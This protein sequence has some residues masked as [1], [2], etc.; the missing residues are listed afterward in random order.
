MDKIE[1]YII[2]FSKCVLNERHGTYGGQAGLKD[3]VVY[4]KENWIIKY[5]K[6]TRGMSDVE[7]LSYTTA[8]LSEYIGS[9]IYQILGFDAH[10]TL[11]GIRNNKLVVGCKDFRDDDELLLE[12]RT[13]KNAA[14]AELAD[15]LDRDFSETGSQHTVNLEELMTHLKQ[16]DILKNI[17]GLEEYFWNCVVVDILINNNDRNNGNWGILRKKGCADRIAPIFDNGGCLSNKLPEERILKMLSNGDAVSSSALNTVTVFRLNDKQLTARQML[18]L[19]I[20]ELQDA[21]CRLIPQMID[22]QDIIAKFIQDIPV[23]YNGIQVCTKERAKF[24]IESMKCRL[25][26]LLVPEYNKLCNSNKA[27]GISHCKHR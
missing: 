20:P 19:S 6:N 5:A 17:P 18:Q 15:K 10:E 2:D 16:N 26:K 1:T 21:I 13:I 3:G 14:N 7:G 23:E 4:N 12:I 25:E 9:H 22:K 11:L 27:Q 8:P 24:Y